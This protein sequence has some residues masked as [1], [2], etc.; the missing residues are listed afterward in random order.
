MRLA[1]PKRADDL[2]SRLSE[3]SA[4][5]LE[6]GS[7]DELFALLGEHL[8]FAAWELDGPVLRLRH[9]TW[10]PMVDYAFGGPGQEGLTVDVDSVPS[11]PHFFSS[12]RFRRFPAV[13]EF[14]ENVVRSLCDSRGRRL[15]ES[16][17]RTFLEHS[18]HL[19]G[20]QGPIFVSGAPWGI[21]ILEWNDPS[22]ADLDLFTLFGAQFGAALEL[23][24]QREGLVRANREL[25]AIR[26]L[27]RKQVEDAV[28]VYRPGLETAAIVT[29]SDAASLFWVEPGNRIHLLL[30]YGVPCAWAQGN[31][32]GRDETFE[33]VLSSMEAATVEPGEPDRP[34]LAL[35]PLVVGKRTRGILV[36]ARHGKGRAYSRQE[37]IRAGLLASQLAVQLENAALLEETR[38]QYELISGLYRFSRQLARAREGELP[39][40]DSLDTLVANLGLMGAWLYVADE[41]GLAL[42]ASAGESQDPAPDV[43]P[44]DSDNPLALAV[45][46]RKVWYGPCVVA[47]NA[48]SL[49]ALPLVSSN[50]IVGCLAVGR[51]KGDVFRRRDVELLQ[52]V[53]V[54]IALAVQ[55][56]RLERSERERVRQLR[57]LSEVGRITTSK[58]LDRESLLP[59]FLSHLVERLGLDFSLAI[60]G[61]RSYPYGET[62][63]EEVIEALQEQAE[64]VAARGETEAQA[65]AVWGQEI[66]HLA[67]VPARSPAG[68]QA[69]IGVVRR[70]MPI[71]GQEID[72]L[73]A[74]GSNLG[75]ALEDAHRFEETQRNLDELELLLE[76][77]QAVT[78]TTR[79]DEVLHRTAKIVDRLAGGTRTAILLLDP[80]QREA[81]CEALSNAEGTRLRTGM[82]FPVDLRS[83]SREPEVVEDLRTGPPRI[84]QAFEPLGVKSALV[85]HMHI[86]DAPIGC[87]VVL[88]ETGPRKWP[89]ALVERVR[90]VSHQLAIAVANARLDADLRASHRALARA[91]K[92]LV[93]KERLAV[94]GELSAVVAHEVRNPL[95]VIF[96]SISS[97]RRLVRLE[98]DAKTLFEIVEEEANRLD[99]IVNDLL[100]FARPHP[101]N[102]S[103]VDVGALVSSALSTYPRP[104][105]IALELVVEEDLPEVHADERLV[106]QALLN[107][108]QNA[109]HAMPKGGSLRVETRRAERD[110]KR[111]VQI[112]VTDH[113]PGIPE[114]IRNKIFEPFFTTK[115]TGSG[116]GLALVKR[117]VEAHGG[118][119]LLRTA[120]GE[121]STFILEFEAPE[122]A[123]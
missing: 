42:A 123:S 52:S 2:A 12:R 21:L 36:L 64:A 9:T 98:G 45:R 49:L 43:I 35:F 117:I 122:R 32:H 29:E 39:L 115:A 68:V 8:N 57:F 94:L 19:D 54:Q 22:D 30:H 101:A 16:V 96:N 34:A 18:R 41:G 23:L 67:A 51:K 11:A 76:V 79:L 20:V 74:A 78:S 109:I 89:A 61:G 33:Q 24:A 6:V 73:V 58:R 3:L 15:P 110:G 40:E 93:E 103:W 112:A 118:R 31:V 75:F 70:G 63:P 84:R 46:R 108:V 50:Q 7:T 85:V 120:L 38:R 114:E 104:E 69:V 60:A 107:L 102:P 81:R 71:S 72:T 4:A 26:T 119:V 27:A 53:C 25:Q 62:P 99:R 80:L 113:G 17:I 56:G 66:A 106:R 48:A 5:L 37:V 14:R 10:E 95:G 86:L 100:E 65:Q 105:S 121:G 1:A 47:P 116:L 97:L 90:L 44:A 59:E 82:Q 88:D 83:L 13:R 55:R 91:Q 92:E 87:I 28:G 111:Y 77:G